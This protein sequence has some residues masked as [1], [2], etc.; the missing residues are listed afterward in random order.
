MKVKFCV[1]LETTA[2]CHITHFTR[3]F[4]DLLINEIKLE[5]AVWATET[6][7]ISII[8]WNYYIYIHIS[9]KNN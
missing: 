5:L 7:T 3:I 1:F 9:S 8:F 4:N 2:H 6:Q